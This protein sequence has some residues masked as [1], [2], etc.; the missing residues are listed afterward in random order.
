MIVIT[1]TNC[2]PKLRGDLTK[3]LLEIN[4]G[5]YVGNVSARVREALWSRVCE[6]INDGQATLVY[7]SANE[8]HLE[9]K[10]HNS[11]WKIRDFDG[12]KLIM[13]PN[14]QTRTSEELPPGFSKMS[15]YLIAGRRKNQ[16]KYSEDTWVFID[17]ETTGLD[18]EKDKIIE[19]AALE[20]NAD[21]IISSWSTLVKIDEELSPKIVE[22]TGITNEVIKDGSDIEQ[23]LR[24]FGGR[25]A[26]KR[27]VCYNRRFDI[28]ILDRAFKDNQL[29][30]PVG[31][32]I[33]ALSLARKRI[34]GIENYQLS[35]LA[36]FFEIPVEDRHR[37]AVDCELLY[38]VFLKLNEI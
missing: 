9:F 3:W 32:V 23:A 12:I 34:D 4:T 2:P 17:I 26:G 29:E 28:D 20:A 5:V 14:V 30:F 25:I 13:R 22:L 38:R 1:M 31:K 35:T 15:K 8:Q 27:V 21:E 6:N 16:K 10:T 7:N 37:A 24:E 33:D 36:E 11:A 19:L 18:V